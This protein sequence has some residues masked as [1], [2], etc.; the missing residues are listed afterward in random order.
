MRRPAGRVPATML[1]GLT[2]GVAGTTCMTLTLWAEKRARRGLT[3]PVDYDTS[4]HV[5]TAAS[6]RVKVR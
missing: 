6:L 2:A 4:S 1:R 3:R 5:V